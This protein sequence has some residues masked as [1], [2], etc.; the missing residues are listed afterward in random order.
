[1]RQGFEETLTG[2]TKHTMTSSGGSAESL[3]P[4]SF[5]PFFQK[6]HNTCS[7]KCKRLILMAISNLQVLYC[8]FFFAIDS[9]YAQLGYILFPL[10][11]PAQPSPSLPTGPLTLNRETGRLRTFYFRRTS[12]VNHLLRRVLQTIG[13][14]LSIFA[15]DRI[16]IQ[17][18]AMA[19]IFRRAANKVINSRDGHGSLGL[20]IFDEKVVYESFQ[21]LIIAKADGKFHLCWKALFT[22][23]FLH[24][25]TDLGINAWRVDLDRCR[26]FL[27]YKI[28][29]QTGFYLFRIF[30]I[31]VL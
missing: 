29:A 30:L 3:Y 10:P 20:L 6:A 19:R 13:E 7:N 22:G 26:E 9:F 18:T 4:F 31:R 1:M 12:L 15:L 21:K 27:V 2:G 25:L 8:R 16:S 14:Y 17:G 11:V 5:S 23:Y 24:W 28:S